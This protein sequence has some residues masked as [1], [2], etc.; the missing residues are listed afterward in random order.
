MAKGLLAI[1][2]GVLVQQASAESFDL[3]C[4]RRW[5]V[6]AMMPQS[7]SREPPGPERYQIDLSSMRWSSDSG[8]RGRIYRATQSELVLEYEVDGEDRT[9]HAISR[10]DGSGYYRNTYKG[11]VHAH[12]RIWDCKKVPFTGLPQRQRRF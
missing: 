11:E 3:Q 8:D 10:I 2:L 12:K 4:M 1:T 7:E 6:L 5:T 9:L